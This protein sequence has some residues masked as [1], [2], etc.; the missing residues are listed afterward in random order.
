LS[1]DSDAGQGQ[2][3]GFPRRTLVLLGLGILLTVA[4]LYAFADIGE[5]FS[6][7]ASANLLVYSLSFLSVTLGTLAYTLAWHVLLRDAGVRIGVLR[8]WGIVWVSVFLNILVPTGSVGGELARVYLIT[9]G[10]QKEENKR[11]PGELTATIIAHRVITMM[12]FLL[13]S[14]AGFIYLALAYKASGFILGLASLMVV[15]L[16]GTFL[17]ICYLCFSPKRIEGF[18]HGCLR[19]IRHLSIGRLNRRLDESQV[20]IDENLE[21]F[22]HGIET[23]R[24][25]PKSLGLASAFSAL[26]WVLDAL[27]AYFA[28]QAIDFPIPLA[29]LVFVYTIGVTIQMVPVGIPGMIGVVEVTMI[30]L[31]SA[32]GI[33]AEVGAA[34]TMLIRIVMLWFEALVGGVVTYLILLRGGI[35]EG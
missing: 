22:Q 29:T 8:E 18:V 16:L 13:G 26:F 19:L 3:I 27:V 20:L 28:F 7:I 11:S 6:I 10:P 15:L 5:A 1:A 23:L 32:T 2:K 21:A 31:Y 9:K 35:H 30:T 14:V 34:A 25:N 4:F 33:P 24:H 17:G 12:P